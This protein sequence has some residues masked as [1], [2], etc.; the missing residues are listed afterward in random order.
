MVDASTGLEN[1]AVIGLS[2]ATLIAPFTGLVE[3]T[4]GGV[5]SNAAM[6]V[7]LLVMLTIQAPVP[8]QAPDHPVNVEPASSSAVKVTLVP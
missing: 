1:V 3:I 8:E 7:L 5:L 2:M 4:A 6:T